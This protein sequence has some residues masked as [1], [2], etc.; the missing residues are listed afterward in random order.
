MGFVAQIGVNKRVSLTFCNVSYAS[1][2]KVERLVAMP[3]KLCCG[4]GFH[5]GLSIEFYFMGNLR[6]VYSSK[7]C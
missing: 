7:F 4:T 6:N 3:T 1:F 5:P 2:V